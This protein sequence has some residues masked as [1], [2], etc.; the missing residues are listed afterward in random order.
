MKLS[1]NRMRK[2]L[3]PLFI[4]VFIFLVL[5]QNY[6]FIQ[7]DN[8]PPI[9]DI[10]RH[11][12][13]ISEY[14]AP[15]QFTPGQLIHRD[16]YPPLAHLVGLLFFKVLKPSAD[17]SAFSLFVFIVI[18][19]LSL[20]GIGYEYGGHY[21]G[22]AVMAL[23][24]SSPHIINYSR[25]FY[26]DFPETAMTALAFYVLL[27]TC[28]YRN[29]FY[30]ILLGFVLCLAFFTKWSMTFF[31]FLPLIWFVFPH[32]IRNLRSFI[33]SGLFGALMVFFMLRIRHFIH[34][35]REL[36]VDE[37]FKITAINFWLPGFL[38]ALILFL[39]IKFRGKGWD[40]KTLE[41]VNG[42]LNA[43]IAGL[44]VVF[45]ASPWLL[46]SSREVLDKINLDTGNF[47]NFWSRLSEI[48]KII[49]ISYNYLPLLI[50]T[51]VVFLC[52]YH[53]REN[54]SPEVRGIFYRL[55]LPVNLIFCLFLMS[56]I[57]PTDIR[58][59]LSF[60][61]F[62]AVLGG[63][64]VG[65][66]GK[67]RIPVTVVIV[68][69]SLLSITGWLFVPQGEGIFQIISPAP[70]MNGTGNP[71]ISAAILL[72]AYPSPQKYEVEPIMKILRNEAGG[73][74]ETILWI[75]EGDEPIVLDYIR[76]LCL[77]EHL[78]FNYEN[79]WNDGSN[80]DKLKKGKIIFI[81]CHTEKFKEKELDDIKTQRSGEQPDIQRFD[82]PDDYRLYLLRFK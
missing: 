62:L 35:N 9:S 37:V 28:G 3:P 4:F 71:R 13:K 66:T 43:A 11:I 75:F 38:F 24:A 18:F 30:S 79:I 10:P 77:S 48:L 81:S 45:P 46:W 52:I 23:G 19:L 29:R 25:V 49:L 50:L 56:Y 39:W 54:F 76:F 7:R 1:G 31:L 15:N 5:L 68:L 12:S 8:S 67:A 60:I 42:I 57:S 59:M 26:I 40:E 22:A 27:K 78:R 16:P 34:L 41:S 69:L 72:P 21:S 6:I 36:P 20:Y 44:M 2:I 51:G 32:V 73:E 61:T 80:R 55:I 64:W 33:V 53:E 58:Y 74:P 17:A 47:G 65:W 63:W 14:M 82:Y 70:Y